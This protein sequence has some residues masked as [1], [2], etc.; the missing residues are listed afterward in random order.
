VNGAGVAHWPQSR[1]DRI[2]ITDAAGTVLDSCPV[3]PDGDRPRPQMLWNTGWCAYPG[4]E[5]QEKLP[6]QWA[7]AVFNHELIQKGASRDG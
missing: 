3:T 7:V 2:V 1:W 6:G 5:W 4:S